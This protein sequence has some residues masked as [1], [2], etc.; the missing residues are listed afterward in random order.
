MKFPS[1]ITAPLVLICLSLLAGTAPAQNIAPFEVTP[2]PAGRS[3]HGTA[4]A[5]GHVFVIS[6]QTQSGPTPTVLA[7]PIQD[8]RSLGQWR[9]ARPLPAPLLYIGNSVITVRDV[10]YVSAG[11]RIHASAARLDERTAPNNLTYYSVVD[12]RGNLGPWQRTSPYPGTKHIGTAVAASPDHL[13]I[14]GGQEEGGIISNSVSYAPLAGDGTPGGWIE[15]RSL[16]AGLWFHNAFY[17]NGRIFVTGGRPGVSDEVVSNSV[18]S[19]SIGADG[20]V[21]AWTSLSRT[22]VAPIN[23]AAACPTGDYFFLFGGRSP[24][25]TVNTTIQYAQVS[26]S[27]ISPWRRTATALPTLYFS[28]A[29]FDERGSAVY[30]AGGFAEVES[31][32]ATTHVACLPLPRQRRDRAI[33]RGPVR[34]P[35]EVSTTQFLGYREAVSLA[36]GENRRIF[37]LCYRAD[38]PV[39]SAVYTRLR[40]SPAF[41]N[42]TMGMVTAVLETSR[43]RDLFSFFDVGGVPAYLVFDTDGT[44]LLKEEGEKTP[45]EIIRLMGITTAGQ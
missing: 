34:E 13:Y 12:A 35:V 30:I 8:D 33:A 18:Y 2:L 32:R 27:N 40:Q 19:A 9:S 38:D 11:E 41:R 14:I 3:L 29:A 22:L 45:E 39:S 10:V 5:A 24:G 44:V 6:G 36:A 7:A 16:P 28:S 26:D 43:D 21:T 31:P 15:T 20:S 42:A 25:D 17:D 1:P 4:V 23:A 37:L